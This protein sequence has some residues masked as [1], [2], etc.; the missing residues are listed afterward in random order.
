[1]LIYEI[2]CAGLNPLPG[3]ND[4]CEGLFQQLPLEY[5]YFYFIKWFIVFMHE[6]GV[7]LISGVALFFNTATLET[8]LMW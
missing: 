2:P 5:L 6:S 1:M 3:C 7:Y 4:N 8:D